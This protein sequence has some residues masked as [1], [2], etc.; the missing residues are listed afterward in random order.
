MEHAFPKN[1]PIVTR[2]WC[3]YDWA[4]SVYSLVI[5]TAIFPIYYVAL[6][7]RPEGDLT[8]FFAWEVSASVLYSYALTGAFL[9]IAFLSPL[10]TAIADYGGNKKNFMRFFCYMGS[11]ACMGLF[12][13]TEQT[14]SLS[15]LLFMI[16]AIGYS[17]SIVFYNAYLP[18]IATEDQFDKLSARGFSLGYIGSMILL[19]L[20][21]A[22]VLFPD[23]VGIE[24][25]GL[26]ARISFLMTGLWWFG[27][28]Q[29]SFAHLPE[30]PYHQKAKGG[31]LFNGFKELGKVFRQLKSLPLLKKFLIAFFFYNM[32]VQT[33]MYVASLFGS[34]E[35]SLPDE[36]LITVLLIIQ[37]VAIGGAYFFAWLSG[38]IGNTKAL[39]VAVVV[40][41]GITIGAYFVTTGTQYYMLAF[42]VGAVMGGV[43]SLS[44]STYSKLLPVTKDHASFFSFYDICDKVGLALGSLAFGLTQQIFGSMRNS[45]LTLLVFFVIGLLVLLTIKSK[46]L[47]ATE[48]LAA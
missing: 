27:F 44:R 13:F 30:N 40:W 5:T 11:L 29:Y 21:L 22:L 16:A 32:G 10:L 14:F 3:F 7:K 18:E 2:A 46:K 9:I 26:P 23:L 24:D 8:R 36:S 43:Q 33:V 34:K 47:A 48:E 4:N 39:A 25:K 35:L 45:I 19:I 42:V 1:D 20:S 17:G 28:S 31:Y 12:F 15:V 37:A 41:V 38:R 6:T